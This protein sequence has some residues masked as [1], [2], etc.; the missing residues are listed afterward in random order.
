MRPNRHHELGQ[1]YEFE[2]NKAVIGDSEIERPVYDSSDGPVPKG[3]RG[4]GRGAKGDVFVS[5]DSFGGKK[6]FGG[7]SG[8]GVRGE[9]QKR[10]AIGENF[11]EDD[12][13][14]MHESGE[15]DPRLFRWAGFRDRLI[16]LERHTL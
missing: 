15:I 12:D 11:L 14:E 9:G 3:G 7:R 10:E 16:A 13:S 4:Q 8:N 5:G 1:T 2:E 6:G